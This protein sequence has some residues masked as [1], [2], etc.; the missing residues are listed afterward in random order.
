MRVLTAT[1]LIV[2]LSA[3]LALAQERGSAGNLQPQAVGEKQAIEQKRAAEI[4]T[5]VPFE[6]PVKGA[7]YSA[8]III[9]SSQTLADGNHISNKNVGHVYRDGEGRTRREQDGAV[10]V[11]TRNEPV[12]TTKSMMI[13]IVDPVAG[14]SYSL[15]P[16]QKIAWRTPIGASKEL[17]DKIQVV[18]AQRSSQPLTDEQK[19]RMADELK[20][21]KA[22]AEKIAVAKERAAQSADGPSKASSEVIA[23]AGGRGGLTGYAFI[24]PGPLEHAT[25]D[26]LAVEGRKTSE[27]IP[28]GKIG[29]DQPITITSEEWRSP[30]LK[31][32]VLTKHNDPRTGESIYRLGNV[33]RAEPDPSLFM[34]PPDYTVKDTN[35]RRN[36]E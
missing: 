17:L 10:L 1:S 6:T 35:I 24:E 30:D 29:N 7:P 14:Y 2:L 8:D 18:A 9:Q 20:M 26:G 23:R 32:L 4:A 12:I 15:N 11:V 31:V 16:E 36:N 5:R 27:T 13:S 19:A 3:P 22:D 25:I 33:V 21:A 34:V 28:A